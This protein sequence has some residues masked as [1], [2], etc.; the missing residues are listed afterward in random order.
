MTSKDKQ[1]QTKIDDEIRKYNNLKSAFSTI[2]ESE[3]E[4]QKKRLEVYDKISKIEESDNSE[5]AQI[6][7]QFFAKMNELEAP[8][9]KH[10]K[11][12]NEKF[13][14]MTVYYPEKLKQS[15]KSI[16][17][18]VTLKKQ[19]EKNAKEEQK[20]Q[21]KND[22]DKARNLSA[23]I[24]QQS[25]EERRKTQ[26]IERNVCLIEADRVKDNKYLFL[27]Y[28]HSEMEYHAKAVEKM[29]QLFNMI[30]RIEPL[31]K[32]PDF[33]RNYNIKTDLREI[34]VDIEEI[35]RN[36]EKRIREEQEQ[37]NKVFGGNNGP[38]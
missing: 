29:S 34:D 38:N 14:P 27:H 37:V 19:K 4:V 23:Q 18:L 10:L 7:K 16:D 28:I 32:L 13:L 6:Y 25:E 31:E 11:N 21:N 30:N 20:A 5:L 15:K 22:V 12:I 26:D 33:A 17:D 8:R 24:A 35:E 36:K 1:L 9:T 2:Y 3:N